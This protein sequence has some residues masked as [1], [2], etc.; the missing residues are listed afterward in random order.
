MYEFISELLC[1]QQT[2]SQ[3]IEKNKS[4]T[5]ELCPKPCPRRKAEEQICLL[6][7]Q[8]DLFAMDVKGLRC[9]RHEQARP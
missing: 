6:L 8:K 5:L 2:Y 4:K 3:V 9:L 7:K 1:Y